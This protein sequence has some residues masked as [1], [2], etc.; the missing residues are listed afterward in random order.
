MA[1]PPTDDLDRLAPLAEPVRRRLY[2]FVVDQGV[3]VDRDEA[4]LAAGISRGLAAFHLDRLAEAGLLDV[5]FRRRSGRS[6]PGAGRP[7]K[8]YRRAAGPGISVSLPARHYDVAADILA[9]GVERR[10]GVASA[11]RD[12]ARARAG[13][14]LDRLG[15]RPSGPAGAIEVLTNEG[16]EP[17]AEADGTVTL[18]NCPFDALVQDHRQVT[19]SMNLALVDGIVSGVTEPGLVAAPRPRE[20]TCCVVLVPSRDRGDVGG[21]TPEAGD[22]HAGG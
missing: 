8:Y 17:V 7:A 2:A 16:Y 20:G 14:V 13:R 19:C 22:G 21:A 5:E 10:P 15:P 11:I 3:P 6:G 9:S 12:A 1:T 18:R 4:A